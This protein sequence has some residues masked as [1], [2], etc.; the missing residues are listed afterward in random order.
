MMTMG[1]PEALHD[2]RMTLQF[3]TQTL[4]FDLYDT[5]LDR[6]SK[7]VPAIAGVFEAHDH[8][9]DPEI[10][11]RRYLAMHFR[12]SL[13][14]SLVSGEHTPFKEITRRALEY[15]FAQ[16]GVPATD[17]EVQ[18]VVETWNTFEAYDDAV[19]PLQ[20]LGKHYELVGLSNGDPDMLNA[21]TDDLAV[22][23]DGVVSVADAGRYKPHPAP[24][25]LCCE[26]YDVD[27]GDVTFVSA[28]TFDIV[29]ARAVGM[30]GAYLNRH[31]RP[32]GG[33]PQQPTVEV[34][35]ADGLAEALL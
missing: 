18:T 16:V 26:R 24:Y 1:A 6:E 13:I 21:V 19:E 9:A 12:D 14:D 34:G 27:A 11:L 22:D 10:F 35:S 33:W 2:D 31:D 23:L 25:D 30:D 28:H 4:A 20:R 8:D 5:V 17:A 7:L 32:Y 3:V 15:R 29:G